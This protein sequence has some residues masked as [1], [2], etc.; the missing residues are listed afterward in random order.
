ME[1]F[2]A[3]EVSKVSSAYLVASYNPTTPTSVLPVV[4]TASIN[5]RSLQLKHPHQW[6]RLSRLRRLIR[7]LALVLTS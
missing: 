2:T 4:R 7:S 3:S 6:A 5:S 1:R